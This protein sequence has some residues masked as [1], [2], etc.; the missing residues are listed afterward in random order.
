MN[1]FIKKAIKKVVG[2]KNTEKAFKAS[3]AMKAR[4]AEQKPS[5][6]LLDISASCNASCPFCPRIYMEEDRKN[7]FMEV[8]LFSFALKEAKDWGIKRL[9]LHS[10]AEPLLHPKFAELID[11]ARSMDF[12]IVLS[13]NASTL[14]RHF[15][16]LLKVDKLNF[17]VEGWDR[18]SYERFRDPLSFDKCYDNI[19]DFDKLMN[20]KGLSMPL[21]SINLLL[22]VETDIEKFF[23]LWGALADEIR[24]TPMYPNAIFEDGRITGKANDEL[25]DIFF[26]FEIG[27]TYRCAWPFYS[28]VV[29]Y[30]GK[31]SLCCNDFSSSFDIGN[32]RDGIKKIYNSP[33]MKKV[34]KEFTTNNLDICRACNVFLKPT[35]TDQKIIDEMLGNIKHIKQPKARVLINPNI[36][37][38][39]DEV[40]TGL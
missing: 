16:A 30:D 32:I 27:D 23:E 3:I 38:C 18:E 39:I 35:E 11:I 24:I 4:L 6:I 40:A 31:I 33:F 7:G 21:R 17:S 26:N 19:K 22:T 37:E 10:V 15:D 25:K 2:A 34:R 36:D 28:V 29:S 8:D 13:T 5:E 1:S 20:E 9:K 12:Y 14:E